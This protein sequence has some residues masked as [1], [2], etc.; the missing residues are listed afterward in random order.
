[1]WEALKAVI[2]RKIISWCA[3]NNKKQLRLN[4]ELKNIE[5]QHKRAPTSNLLTKL[6]KIRNESDLLY[7]QE[8]EKKMIFIKQKYYESGPRL[9]K[10]LARSL[11]KLRAD[12]TI[13]KIKDPASNIL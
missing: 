10:I 1:M 7:T 12:N 5:V 3:Y 6:N 11:Q 8:I 9:A 2:R 4:K 13:Y